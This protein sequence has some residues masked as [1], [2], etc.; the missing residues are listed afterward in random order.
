MVKGAPLKC[1]SSGSTTTA[2]RDVR[3]GIREGLKVVF[4]K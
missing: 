4:V 1:T 3:K 2:A